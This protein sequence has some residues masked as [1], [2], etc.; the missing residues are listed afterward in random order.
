MDVV[1]HD[2]DAFLSAGADGVVFGAL[3]ESGAVAVDACRK[4]VERSRGRVV[5]HR[6]FDFTQDLTQVLDQLIGLGFERVLTSG[7]KPTAREGSA[8][9]SDLMVRAAGRIEIL[10]GG[11]IRPDNVAELVHAT[12]CNQVHAAARSTVSDSTLQTNLDL[13]PAMGADT[14]GNRTGTDI[15]LVA[16]LRAALDRLT[17]LR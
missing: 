8:V 10:P 12:G 13:A 16:G 7:G 3:E 2:A 9:L 4:V 17:S 11:G 5:F 15:T 14:V 1:L 6:A